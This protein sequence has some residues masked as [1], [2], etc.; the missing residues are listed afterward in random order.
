MYKDSL[1]IILQLYLIL[2]IVPSVGIWKAARAGEGRWDIT[3][4]WFWGF[5]SSE[6]SEVCRATCHYI[7]HDQ[8]QVWSPEP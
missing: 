1:E 6:L 8:R 3:D 5:N 4:H 2:A 7:R